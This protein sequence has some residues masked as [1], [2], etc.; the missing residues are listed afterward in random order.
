MINVFYSFVISLHSWKNVSNSFHFLFSFP[1]WSF[2]VMEFNCFSCCGCRFGFSHFPQD[3]FYC[4]KLLSVATFYVFS[5]FEVARITRLTSVHKSW[6]LGRLTGKFLK[7][8]QDTELVILANTHI[9]LISQGGRTNTHSKYESITHQG[10]NYKDKRWLTTARL[11][12]LSHCRL[13]AG[14]LGRWPKGARLG[15]PLSTHNPAE[16]QRKGR[17]EKG[18]PGWQQ[19]FC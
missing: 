9:T 2:S 8:H 15:S 11:F 12:R 19:R 13:V 10:T 16:L 14:K 7:F 6:L 17:T 4:Q 3:T 1:A 18:A 5:W